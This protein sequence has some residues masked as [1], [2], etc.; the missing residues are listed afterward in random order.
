MAAYTPPVG[1]A[2]LAIAGTY[3]PPVGVADLLIGA[4]TEDN[5]TLA[6][7]AD[8]VAPVASGQFL[9]SRVLTGAAWTVAPTANGVLGKATILTGAA[10]TVAPIAQGQIRQVRQLTGIVTTATPAL[11]GSASYDVNLL[12]AYTATTDNHWHEAFRISREPASVWQPAQRQDASGLGRWQEAQP[13]R[14]GHIAHWTAALSQNATYNNAWTD[15]ALRYG[16]QFIDWQ[17]AERIVHATGADWQ[18]GYH[19]EHSARSDFQIRLP[20]LTPQW[21]GVWQQGRI[22]VRGWMNRFQD[23]TLAVQ[24]EIEVWQQGGYPWNAQRPGPPIPPPS[25]PPDWGTNLRIICPLPGTTL[26]IGRTACILIAEREIPKQRTYM[27]T[28]SAALVRWPDLTPLPCT[29]LSIETDFDSWCWA[30]SA[31]LAGPEAWPLVQPNPL[32]CE[33][34]ATING[35]VWRFLLDVPSTQRSFNSDRISLKGRSRS[36][37]LHDPYTPNRDF[38]ETEAREMV[39]LAE[40]A[41]DNTGWTVDWQL[42]NWVVPAGLWTQYSTPIESLIRLATTTAD[43]VYTHPSDAIITLQKRWPVASWLLDAATTDLLIPEDAVISL[44]QAPV[45]TQPLNGVY[46]SGTTAGALALVKIAGTDGALQPTEPIT[47]ALLCD[48]AGVAARQRG[49]N[50]LSDSGAGWEMDAEVLL[51]PAIGLVQPGMVI[52]I[53]GMKGI[54]RSCRISAQ[55]SGDGLQVRQ[56]VTLER[57]EV[58]T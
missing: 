26:Q 55:W 48:A 34:Q 2:D 18:D 27:S 17:Q 37:W 3:T 50:A 23:G 13:A 29:A 53:A 43:G 5:R 57:R 8:T 9:K 31:T 39:Q 32:A 51:T 47:E 40:A 10:D 28:N 12:S 45:Y 20:L 36:A 30:L 38:S 14:I 58:E 46:V 52:S 22:E 19:Q 16:T 24:F 41:L 7:A 49:L 11:A 54:S 33:V 4:S 56:T 15:A 25:S 6:G 44:S 1:V 35:Q 21:R 42:E